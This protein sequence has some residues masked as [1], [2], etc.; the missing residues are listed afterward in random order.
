MPLPVILVVKKG[1]K[2]RPTVSTSM[3]LPVSLIAIADIGSPAPEDTF[4]TAI[5]SVPPSGMA[6]RALEATLRIA[7]WSWL[8]STV[9]GQLP[10]RLVSIRIRSP[11]VRSR[12]SVMLADQRGEVDELGLQRLAAREG[13]QLRGEDRGVLGGLDDGFGEAL[14]ALVGEVVAAEDVGRALDDG[15]EI[16]EVVRDAAGQLAERLHLLALAKLVLG[17]GALLHL[18]GEK[19]VGLAERLGALAQLLVGAAKRGLRH[20]ERE[21]DERRHDGEGAEDDIAREP[22]RQGLALDLV[23]DRADALARALDRD[24]GPVV[25]VRRR[26]AAGRG[27]SERFAPTRS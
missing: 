21:D 17:L 7:D 25:A 8:R 4:D 10:P 5:R 22:A 24:G 9:T 27:R 11:I 12:S 19:L 6:S 20:A 26:R 23:D 15:Q 2:M 14:A 1:S 13:E 18:L 3:P 16:V